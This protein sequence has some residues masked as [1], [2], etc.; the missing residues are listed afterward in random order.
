VLVRLFIGL[1]GGSAIIWGIAT[2]PVFWRQESLERVAH[3]IVDRDVF[4]PHALEALLPEVES[5]SQAKACQPGALRSAAIIRMRLAEEAMAEGE[6]QV[7]DER[8]TSLQA[9]VRRSLTCM[10]A[11][12]FL[13]MVLAWVEG[14]RD[15]FRAEQLNYLR[16]SYA[17]GPNE[18]WIAARRNRLALAIFERLPSDLADA[19]ISEFAHMVDSW[20]YDETLAIFVGPGWA[21][22]DRLLASLEKV[23]QLQREAFAKSLYA[24]G[25]DVKVPGVTLRDPRPWY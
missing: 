6:R 3:R 18:G 21:V 1:L 14:A 17:L 2:L 7:I 5:V 15:G 25:Y 16:L 9:V 22:R 19:A 8:L 10:P 4:K 11:D 12:P 13:W 24:Q 20:L 23:G